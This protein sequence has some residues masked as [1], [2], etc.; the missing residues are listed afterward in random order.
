M[1]ISVRIFEKLR[2]KDMSQKQFSQETGISQSTISEMVHANANPT[3]SVRT[4]LKTRCLFPMRSRDFIFTTNV[5][6]T[7]KFSRRSS[8]G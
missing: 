6:P 3:S 8:R 5:A 1:T 7:L 2:Q 4:R